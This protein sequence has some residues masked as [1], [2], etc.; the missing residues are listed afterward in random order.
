MYDGP[1][2]ALTA[3]GRVNLTSK[4]RL[5]A[6]VGRP[7]AGDPEIQ[8]QTKRS[9]FHVELYGDTALISYS[10]EVTATNRRDP[11]TRTTE[12][13]TCLDTFVKRNGNWYGIANCCSS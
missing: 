4:E 1:V 9:D 2:M 7:G 10:Q 12:R 13:T 3:S 5:L 11:A 8:R 6:T